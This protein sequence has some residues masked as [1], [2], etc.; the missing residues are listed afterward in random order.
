MTSPTLHVLDLL[1]HEL[2]NATNVVVMGARLLADGADD[3]GTTSALGE[4]MLDAGQLLALA[5][6]RLIECARCELNGAPPRE[7]FSLIDLVELA[8]RRARRVDSTITLQHAISPEIEV[9]VSVPLA[10]RAIAD[11]M[12]FAGRSDHYVSI[13]CHL[14]SGTAV[15]S[16]QA[17]GPIVPCDDRFNTDRATAL[18]MRTLAQHAQIEL[19]IDEAHCTTTARFNLSNT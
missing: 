9:Q 18:M 2:R 17:R 19:D 3:N 10:E 8:G 14:G 6:D 4:D 12:L 13:S 11:A 1:A 5:V 16:I 15:L 7:S